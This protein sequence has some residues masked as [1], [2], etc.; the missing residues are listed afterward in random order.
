MHATAKSASVI[1]DGVRLHR[2][3]GLLVT[4]VASAGLDAAIISPLLAIDQRSLY[5]K[6]QI[7]HATSLMKS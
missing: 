2:L 6:L 1:R 7:L 3:A 4:A 5:E